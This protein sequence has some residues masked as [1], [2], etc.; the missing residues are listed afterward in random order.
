[1]K[2]RVDNEELLIE[3][4]TLLERITTDVGKAAIIPVMAAAD[5]Q[6]NQLAVFLKNIEKLRDGLSKELKGSVTHFGNKSNVIINDHQKILNGYTKK[7]DKALEIT[8]D[9]LSKILERNSNFE[10]TYIQTND[11]TKNLLS[12]SKK[13]HRNAFSGFEKV[14]QQITI[15]N[16]ILL[17]IQLVILF[18]L[19]VNNLSFQGLS[20]KIAGIFS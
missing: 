17:I 11:E 14:R 2:P 13:L 15:W 9:T 7:Y 20:D 16:S 3:F 1:M 18:F 6:R 4:E 5:E 12:E 8:E 10:Q 19:L